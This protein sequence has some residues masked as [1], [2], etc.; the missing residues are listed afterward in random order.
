M[1]LF[2]LNN[3]KY[4]Q[5]GRSMQEKHSNL[6]KIKLLFAFC[7]TVSFGLTLGNQAFAHHSF[8]AT[9]DLNKKIEVEGIIQKFSFKNPHLIIQLAV[10]DPKGSTTNWMVEGEAATRYRH[11]GWDKNTLKPGD[12]IRVTG[13]GTR[14]GSN[15]IYIEDVNILN[16]ETG[17]VTATI[18]HNINLSSALA[19]GTEKPEAAAT[20]ATTIAVTLNSGEPNFTGAWIEN[21]ATSARPPWG[22]DPEL[23]FNSLGKAIQDSWDLSNDPQIFCDPAGL[24]RKSGFTPHPLS[25]KQYDDRVVFTYEEYSGERIVYLNKPI[26]KNAKASAMGS[27][28]ARY[29]DGKLII[30]STN[31]LSN[32]TSL[33]GNYYSDQASVIEVYERSDDP[34]Y[35]S[36][37]TT[38]M[39]VTDPKY[40]TKPWTISR[41]KVYSKGYQ[42]TPTECQLP[43]REQAPAITIP[44]E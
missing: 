18:N 10:S 4:L 23:P 9:Y 17:N 28:T 32:P 21:R 39:T 5:R 43:L 2:T 31:L 33:L 15:M 37:V 8:S 29:E 26:P 16:P 12:R 13:N 44:T 34:R 3:K 30:E 11:A 38:T 6:S 36:Q 27:S 35:G 24:V 25:I 42:L 20:E 7:L 19:G 22:K 1:L 40:F 41:T 14:D